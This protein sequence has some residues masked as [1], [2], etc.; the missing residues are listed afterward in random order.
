MSHDGSNN[1]NSHPRRAHGA[2]IHEWSSIHSCPARQRAMS[3]PKPST[4]SSLEPLASPC[5]RPFSLKNH[6]KGEARQHMSATRFAIKKSRLCHLM[7]PSPIAPFEGAGARPATI[8]AEAGVLL[9]RADHCRCVSGRFCPATGPW[10]SMYG[11]NQDA[12]ENSRLARQ[13]NRKGC[14][15]FHQKDMD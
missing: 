15:S 14:R 8:F 11:V 5:V 12:A 6:L 4:P 2:S 9:I 13:V 3:T 7:S 1:S 10:G